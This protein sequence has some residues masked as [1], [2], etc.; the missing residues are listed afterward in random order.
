MGQAGGQRRR[1]VHE[2]AQMACT[3]VRA[4]PLPTPLPRKRKRR[5][6]SSGKVLFSNFLVIAIV[7]SV[8]KHRQAPVHAFFN[9]KRAVGRGNGEWCNWYR[10]TWLCTLAPGPVPAKRNPQVALIEGTFKLCQSLIAAENVFHR[11]LGHS[12]SQ[13]P[14]TNKVH[15]SRGKHYQYNSN[16]FNNLC[17]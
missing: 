5:A 16:C 6:P 2:P 14:L 17:A 3:A 10:K 4:A 8:D 7:C 11:Q 1:Q 12:A 13:V 15:C 9:N